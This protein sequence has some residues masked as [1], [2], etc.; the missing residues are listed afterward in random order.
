MGLVMRTVIATK[1]SALVWALMMCLTAAVLTP[2]PAHAAFPDHRIRLIVPFAPGGGVDIIARILAEFMS[3][4]LGQP[5]IVEN[6][7]GAGTI[8]GTQEVARA[9][10]DGYTLML[11]SPAFTINMTRRGFLRF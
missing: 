3:K 6:K 5:V 9:T 1:S 11:G 4:D 10:P 8:V 7:P 2:Q